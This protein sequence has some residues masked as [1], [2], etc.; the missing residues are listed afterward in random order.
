MIR[1]H[2]LAAVALAAALVVSACGGSDDTESSSATTAPGKVDTSS[3]IT[4]KGPDGSG[5]APDAVAVAVRIDVD[6]FDP[7]TSLGDSA[8]QQA[9]LFLYDTMVHRTLDGEILPGVASEWEV[10]PTKGVFTIRD[11]LTCTDGTPLDATAVAAS[12]ESLG[13]NPGSLGKSK[14]FGP[15]GMASVTADPA[16]KTV[17]IETKSP[18]NDML[19]GLATTG[20]IVCPAG[21]ADPATIKEAPAGSGPYELTDSKR[22]DEYTLKLRDDYSGFFDDT[23]I[24]D[25]PKT[26]TLKVITDDAAAA[27][28]VESGKIQIAG[29]LSTDA[30]R[31]LANPDLVSV[32]AQGYGSNAVLMMQKPSAATS[33]EK[34][35]QGIAM[36]LDSVQGGAAETQGLGTP[37][38][39]LYTPNIDCYTPDAEA[40]APEYDPAAAAAFLDEAGYKVGADGKRTKPDGSEL[41]IKVVGNNTQGQIPQFIADSLEKGDID[42]DLFVGTYNESI[43]KLLS[44]QFDIG[45]YPFT[46]SSPLPSLWP[47]QIG[48]NAGANFGQVNNTEFDRLVNE[49]LAVDSATDP[50]GRCEKWQEAEKVVLE[51]ANV[52]PMDQPTNN[53]FGNGVTFNSQFFKID[54]FSIRSK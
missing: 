7:H 39:T 45:S 31:L 13:N 47:N 21:L 33:D 48:S 54:P 20:F 50:E 2:R 43:A 24:A 5:P 51:A 18:N 41:T 3:D 4:G 14:I 35:R 12:Y 17:T 10:T 6:S 37:R 44:D 53:W 28:L 42:V 23:T 22:G 52:V 16:A 29:I 11:G 26:V 49:A 46:D 36:L 38:R 34:L 19:T 30:K 27:D 15:D 1:S 8:A 40:Y 9:F 32:P 25:L